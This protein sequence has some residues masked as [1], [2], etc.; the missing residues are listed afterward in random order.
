MR[1]WQDYDTPTLR[2]IRDQ[3]LDRLDTWNLCE[4]HRRVTEW[5]ADTC[6]TEI[7]WRRLDVRGMRG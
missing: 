2:H 6:N 5:V 3:A 7:A 1:H 4:S